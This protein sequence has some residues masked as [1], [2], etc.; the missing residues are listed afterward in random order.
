MP[1]VWEQIGKLREQF[2]AAHVAECIRRGT[3]GEPDWFFAFEAGHVVGTPFKADQRLAQWVLVA[4][5][6]GSKFGC[7]MRPPVQ[8]SAD[9]A[10]RVG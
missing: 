7:V 9:G 2:G 4:A 8:G 1:R 5:A 10:N 3:A 6:M